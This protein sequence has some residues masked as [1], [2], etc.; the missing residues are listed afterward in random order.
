MRIN[1]QNLFLQSYHIKVLLV[2]ILFEINFSV[3][4]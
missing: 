1:I 3:I 2:S 4:L